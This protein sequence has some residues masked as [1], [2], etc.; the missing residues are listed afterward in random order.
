MPYE[1]RPETADRITCP[2]CHRISYSS[3]DVREG[4]C[5]FCHRFTTADRFEL[6][7]QLTERAKELG[8]FPVDASTDWGSA[9]L[10]FRRGGTI[11][12]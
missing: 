9:V 8:W 1:D 6:I 11:G 5:G 7:V 12:R 2:N 3:Y 4:Y 10:S